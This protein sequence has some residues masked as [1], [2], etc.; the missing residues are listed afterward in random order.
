MTFEELAHC[1]EVE[2]FDESPAELHGLLS[3]RIAGGERLPPDNIGAAIV[4]SLGVEEELVDNARDD[5]VTLYA[6]IIASF[7]DE[8]FAFRLLLPGD[9]ISINDRVVALSQWCES[10]LSGLGESGFQGK[11]E[12]SDEVMTAI[13]DLGAIAQVGYEED[14]EDEDEENDFVEIHEYVRMAA[15]VIYSELNFTP[16]VTASS[17][18]H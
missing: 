14:E 18:V 5:L 12:L 2:G 10:F 15:M 7:E 17:T 16:E 13:N 1:L 3:G 9:E 11:A 6:S 8:A 4:E